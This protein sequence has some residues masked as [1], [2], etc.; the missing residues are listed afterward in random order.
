MVLVVG[1]DLGNLSIDGSKDDN[2]DQREHGRD[3]R[4]D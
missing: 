1:Q 4:G 3:D 2:D